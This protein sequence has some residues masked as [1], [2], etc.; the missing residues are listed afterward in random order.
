MPEKDQGCPECRRASL[1]GMAPPLRQVA[2]SDGPIYLYEC[3]RCGA[4][5]EENLRFSQV[6]SQAKAKEDFPDYAGDV[7]HKAD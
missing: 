2:K 3:I 6:V 1:L 7:P 4:L 5:W